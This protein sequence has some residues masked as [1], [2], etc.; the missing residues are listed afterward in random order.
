MLIRTS[1]PSDHPTLLELWRRSVSATHA[2]LTKQDILDIEKEVAGKYL[3]A[4]ELW[5]YESADASLLGFIGLDGSK[6]EMLFAEPARRGQGIGSS[7]LNHARQR[8]GTL[9][10]DVNEQNPKALGF[11]LHYGFKEIGR[12][13]T[14]SAGRPFPLIHLRLDVNV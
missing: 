8:H 3:P 13:A 7:L 11:Y 10:L 5:V 2:F 6:V 4:L 9:T 1:L 14:D 12:S